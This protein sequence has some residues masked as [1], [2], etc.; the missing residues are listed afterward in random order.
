MP[1]MSDKQPLSKVQW[2]L[3]AVAVIAFLVSLS[4]CSSP[5]PGPQPIMRITAPPRQISSEQRQKMEAILTPFAGSEITTFSLIG[6]EESQAF[7]AQLDSVLHEAGWRTAVQTVKPAVGQPGI[8]LRVPKSHIPESKVREYSNSTADVTLTIN[9]L[10][11][12]DIALLKAFRVLS[13]DCPIDTMDTTKDGVE[14][15]IG[16][17]P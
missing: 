16:S 7:G 3:I 6:D 2:V 9:D 1:L 13:M 10:P 14:L 4:K 5:N 17:R 11:P 8:F 15:R 12:Q